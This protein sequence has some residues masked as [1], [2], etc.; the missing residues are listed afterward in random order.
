MAIE[1][2]T[3]TACIIHVG[4]F[5]DKTDGVTIETALTITNERITLTATT[6]DG[7]APTIILDNVT[8]ATSGT[9][10]DL[11]YIS[12]QD[13]GMMQIELSAAN[14]NRY[15]HMKLTINDA[16]NH[17][18]VWED[19]QIVSAQYWDAK[20]GTGLF[21]SDAKAISGDTTAA[22]NCESD[23]DGTGYAG[24]TIVKQADVTKL[25]GTAWLTPGTAGTPDVNVKL[26]SGDATA[27]DN[28]ESDYDGTGYA[29]GT[30]VKQADVTKL[31]GT[32]WLTPGVAGTPDVNVK[33][34]SADATAADNA[35]SFFDGTGYAGT[36]NVIPLVTTTTTAT[37]LTNL[38]ATA[39]TAA[40]LL[41]V[42]KSDSNVT[43]NATALASINAEVDTALNTAIPGSPTSNSVNE[44]VAALDD[45]VTADYGATEKSAVDLLDDGAT[46]AMHQAIALATF[47]YDLATIASGEARRSLLN[48]LRPLLNKFTAAAGAAGYAVYKEDDTT[49]AWTGVLTLDNGVVTGMDPDA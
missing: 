15:G 21:S 34:I 28:C 14:L 9:D 20:Y 18:P 37:N 43:W 6:D 19:L 7:S 44:R 49:S 40:E 3:N 13:N 16:A 1:L 48:A 26:I 27:A 46:G 42:P 36:N 4:P 41:K 23:Y 32:A 47:K 8:G 35:E 11:N 12:G 39:A 5:Y 24:G 10:N 2:K 31:L 17:V 29:G 45:H 30:I 25:L 38:P 33:L 22:D